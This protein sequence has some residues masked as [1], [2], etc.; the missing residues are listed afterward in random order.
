MSY[1]TINSLSGIVKLPML[2]AAY[3]SLTGFS[4]D[5]EDLRGWTDPEGKTNC[6]V[7]GSLEKYIWIGNCQ[8]G[9]ANG[10]GQLIGF[11]GENMALNFAGD[12]K[13]GVR[14][15]KGYLWIQPQNPNEPSIE[16][17]GHFRNGKFLTGTITQNKVVQRYEDGKRLNSINTQ[18][19]QRQGA[20]KALSTTATNN[21]NAGFSF[22]LVNDING[23]TI[24][25]GNGGPC[26]TAEAQ[27]Y[28]IQTLNASG[29][30]RAV[31]DGRWKNDYTIFGF[32][33]L[34]GNTVQANI[35]STQRYAE[36]ISY[37][38]S[39]LSNAQTPYEKAS[40]RLSLAMAECISRNYP[41]YV[42]SVE[43]WVRNNKNLIKD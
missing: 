31:L 30:K 5:P 36:I 38:R 37:A 21:N 15:G 2:V 26:A 19:A 13:N 11:T 16:K 23:T 29:V 33:K 10:Y 24:I 22:R 17:D 32:A 35:N 12:I 28:Q 4:S 39:S 20:E 27:I 1:K 18:S 34:N 25:E 14:D 9:Y 42:V 43:E 40:A 6:R 3:L 7:Q 8:S 41:M